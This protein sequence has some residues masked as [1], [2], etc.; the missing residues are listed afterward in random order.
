M[1]KIGTIKLTWIDPNDYRV[2]SSAMYSTVEQALSNT[3]GKKN[4]LIF[5]LRSVSGDNYSWE[6]LPYGVSD[7]YVTGMKVN[8]NPILK[9]GSYALM[10]L[11]TYYVGS[12]LI[13]K[14]NK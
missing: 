6:L 13:Q 2:L 8:D 4:W 11:G 12:L 10:L 1:Y 14:I 7:K 9:Y 5:K 3:A